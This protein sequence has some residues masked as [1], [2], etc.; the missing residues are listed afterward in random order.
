MLEKM[1]AYKKSKDAEVDKLKDQLY[2][3]QTDIRSLV[4][5]HD[6]AKTKAAEKVRMLTAILHE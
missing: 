4:E 1:E 6:K 3:A 5:E 2:K